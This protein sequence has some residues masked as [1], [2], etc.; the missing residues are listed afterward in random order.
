MEGFQRDRD[1]RPEIS[2]FLHAADIYEAF[3]KPETTTK[4]ERADIFR[5]IVAC[6]TSTYE[7]VWS[8][9]KLQVLD[10][11]RGQEIVNQ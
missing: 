11:D 6:M 4:E 5:V 8:V 10:R 3:A 2:L 7:T 9:L 1:P